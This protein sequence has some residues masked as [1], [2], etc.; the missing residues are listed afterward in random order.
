MLLAVCIACLAG[1]ASASPDAP[2]V[3][4][5]EDASTTEARGLSAKLEALGASRF[6][7]FPYARQVAGHT[8]VYF[9]QLKTGV[10]GKGSIPV[11]AVRPRGSDTWSFDV[12]F[13]REGKPNAELLGRVE[14]LGVTK[15]APL[16]LREY[17][18]SGYPR[19]QFRALRPA[20]GELRA[21]GAVEYGEAEATYFRTAYDKDKSWLIESRDLSGPWKERTRGDGAPCGPIARQDGLQFSEAAVAKIGPARWTALIREDAGT[22]RK[23]RALYQA[24]SLDNACTWSRPQRLG[25]GTQPNLVRVATA[26]GAARLVLCVG[27]R[28]AKGETAEVGIQ[29]R[30]SSVIG[31][32]T[33]RQ[34]LSWGPPRMIYKSTSGSDLGQPSSV[35]VDG[36]TIETFF[37]ADRGLGTKTDILVVRHQVADLVLP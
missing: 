21:W 9:S 34:G 19:V 32:S 1:V 11:V 20:P 24:E 13:D 7:N 35:Q 10:H 25:D 2:R 3:L 27:D 36:D 4:F 18:L 37:Y 22:A 31:G 8:F 14:R 6:S 17:A 28:T 15:D 30:A 23:E 26:D 29:C 5:S 16:V 12:L 33:P